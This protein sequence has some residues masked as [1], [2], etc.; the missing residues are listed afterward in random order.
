MSERALCRVARRGDGWLPLVAVPGHV[1][2]DGP[3]AQRSQLD[4]LA[5]QTGRDPR[6]IDTVLRVSIDAG[7]STERVAGG[8]VFLADRI[9]AG[10]AVSGRTANRSFFTAGT[11]ARA[12]C[13]SGVSVTQL[14]GRG[15]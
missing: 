5:R 11:S 15:T 9:P 1:D 14:P 7:A 12:A 2:V 4:E 3:V 8:I 10:A 6:A 13:S